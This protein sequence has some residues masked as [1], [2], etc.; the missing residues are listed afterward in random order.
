MEGLGRRA[1]PFIERWLVLQRALVCFKTEWK[2]V[3]GEPYSA[4]ASSTVYIGASITRNI[5][6]KQTN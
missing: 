3:G 1:V 6:C 2:D 4:K 5:K